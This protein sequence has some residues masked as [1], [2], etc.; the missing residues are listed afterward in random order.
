LADFFAHWSIETSSSNDFCG[1]QLNP[2]EA[3]PE[4]ADSIL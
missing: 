2:D 1:D 4:A 3:P